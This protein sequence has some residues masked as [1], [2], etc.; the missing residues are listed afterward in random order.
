MHFMLAIYKKKIPTGSE[1]IPVIMMVE[2]KEVIKKYVFYALKSKCLFDKVDWM[3]Y[4]FRSLPRLYE[5]YE[6][7][8]HTT[9]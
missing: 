3:V 9:K 7:I 4:L 1:I 6:N 2:A 5:D 8:R